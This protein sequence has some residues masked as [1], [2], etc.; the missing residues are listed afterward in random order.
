MRLKP[1]CLKPLKHLN[2]HKLH[3]MLKLCFPNVL[4]LGNK[5]FKA[6]PSG[7]SLCT[8]F[9]TDDTETSSMPTSLVDELTAYL[10]LLPI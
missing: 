1:F 9:A 5:V 10:G 4:S 8:G 6:E 3:P 7:V 2:L